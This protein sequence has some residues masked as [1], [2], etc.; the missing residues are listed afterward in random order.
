MG[1]PIAK[2]V[3]DRTASLFLYMKNAFVRMW[4]NWQTRWSVIPVAERPCGFEARHPQQ[5]QSQYNMNVNYTSGAAASKVWRTHSDFTFPDRLTA[6]STLRTS[7][8]LNLAPINFPLASPLGN[9][10][11]PALD[12]INM[13][14]TLFIAC[15]KGFNI[16]K[17]YLVAV[18]K[19]AG[20]ASTQPARNKWPKPLERIL[21]DSLSMCL[22]LKRKAR[23]K[24]RS[25][26]RIVMEGS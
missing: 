3:F 20:S 25:S 12:F 24:C 17:Q 22:G 11:R 19:R 18:N 23:Q 13:C 26:V 9:F 10:G 1:Q 15:V 16:V 6:A 4:R 14:L 2:K 5:K 21:D 7:S 8:G